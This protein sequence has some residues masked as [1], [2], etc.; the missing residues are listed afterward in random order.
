M[1]G[2][3]RV[4]CSASRRVARLTVFSF[5]SVLAPLCPGDL[6]CR[7]GSMYG[8]ANANAT[9]CG[10]SQWQPHTPSANPATW[11]WSS[12][13]IAS[14]DPCSTF[15]TSAACLASPTY[16]GCG[17]CSDST[18]GGGQCQKRN[19]TAAPAQP[20]WMTNVA[21]PVCR[22]N[23]TTGAPSFSFVDRCLSG[24]ASRSSCVGISS[25][26]GCAW[27]GDGSTN[28][29]AANASCQAAT[30]AGFLSGATCA[31]ES[32]LFPAAGYVDPCKQYSSD[33]AACSSAPAELNCGQSLVRHAVGQ[34]PGANSYISCLTLLSCLLL[35]VLQVFVPTG[36]ARISFLK[37]S[38]SRRLG[39]ASPTAAV[40]PTARAT[41]S[42]PIRSL[43][44]VPICARNLRT[45]A[46]AAARRPPHSTAVRHRLHAHT[47]LP[48]RA[49]FSAPVVHAL[50]VSA[51]TCLTECY[52]SLPLSLLLA[53]PTVAPLAAWC[54]SGSKISGSVNASCKTASKNTQCAETPLTR[55][56]TCPV[57]PVDVCASYSA[58]CTTCAGAPAEFNCGQSNDRSGWA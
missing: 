40:S 44:A 50:L 42:T 20:Q 47:D 21:L 18:F 51:L 53:A 34:L 33:C 4:C 29:A 6:S 39:R 15:T 41:V 58:N 22:I 52:L 8:P 55:Y 56:D 11:C 24:S 10:P 46:E 26:L 37:R 13:T 28:P 25:A 1:L 9:V 12:N 57:E 49:L 5:F 54:P 23:E 38:A 7:T 43:Q 27:C 30:A 36:G 2:L 32:F 14:A 3:V 35:Y 17:W 48:M 16:N 45:A 31:A 19:I